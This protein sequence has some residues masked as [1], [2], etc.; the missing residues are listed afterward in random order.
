LRT[1]IA[2]GAEYN[3]LSSLPRGVLNR[4]WSTQ[5]DFTQKD[6]A[7]TSPAA[8]RLEGAAAFPR[9]QQPAADRRKDNSK[10]CV[11]TFV[12][13]PSTASRRQSDI[14]HADGHGRHGFRLWTSS[15][16]RSPTH[17]QNRDRFILPRVTRRCSSLAPPPH[18][19]RHDV[20]G[21]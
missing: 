1:G 6:D 5:P 9:R 8:P 13:S 16:A 19:I 12:S 10:L 17:W 18:H 20:E 15:S 21:G 3:P 14:R 7:S 11:N 2:D 4:V